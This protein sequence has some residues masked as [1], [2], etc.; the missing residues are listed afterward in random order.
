MLDKLNISISRYNISMLCH[1]SYLCGFGAC[2]CLVFGLL[3]I[4]PQKYI[5]LFLSHTYLLIGL[6]II[7]SVCIFIYIKISMISKRLEKNKIIF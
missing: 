1:I 3:I 4:I 7:Y 2:F 5:I 6:S